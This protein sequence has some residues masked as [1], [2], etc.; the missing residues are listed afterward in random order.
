[1][2]ELRWRRQTHTITKHWNQQ[3]LKTH[4]ASS[5]QVHFFYFLNAFFLFIW[6][7]LTVRPP[8]PP[9][10]SK[11]NQATSTHQNGSSSS[12]N[13][14]VSSSMRVGGSSSISSISSHH[15]CQCGTTITKGTWDASWASVFLSLFYCTMYIHLTSLVCFL[16]LECQI[17]AFIS[18]VLI[19]LSWL[20]WLK[21]YLFELLSYA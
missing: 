2:H 7:W 9:Y 5:P 20:V 17:Y 11:L 19:D 6:L 8:P 1:M 13:I 3:G 15:Y 4:C 10:T 12:N 14:S 21:Y 16:Y 18:D